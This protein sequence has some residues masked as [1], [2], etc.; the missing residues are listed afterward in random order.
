MVVVPHHGGICWIEQ[1]PR[2]HRLNVSITKKLVVIFPVPSGKG[3]CRSAVVSQTT[4]EHE[5]NAIRLIK[6]LRFLPKPGLADGKHLAR[7]LD[8]RF[9]K[10][11]MLTLRVTHRVVLGYPQTQIHLSRRRPQIASDAPPIIGV[12]AIRIVTVNY[13]CFHVNCSRVAGAMI[14]AVCPVERVIRLKFI[15]PISLRRVAVRQVGKVARIRIPVAI[16]VDIHLQ[17][18]SHLV[19][20]VLTGCGAGLGFGLQERREQQR[21]Q[22][23]NDGD[24]HEQFNQGKGSSIPA[25]SS[26]VTLTVLRNFAHAIVNVT[27]RSK[28][29]H[30]DGPSSEVALLR[31]MERATLQIRYFTALESACSL[32]QD[33]SQVRNERYFFTSESFRITS[34]G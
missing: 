2:T 8:L 7:H 11:G 6:Y 30:A 12:A 31:R 25:L 3:D 29:S 21:G 10:R 9:S 28:Y 4:A 16:F 13:I 19:Q 22:N 14:G 20:M 5:T 17:G 15:E 18:Q 24:N 32:H 33:A 34:R 27:Q 1:N 26:H 23:A